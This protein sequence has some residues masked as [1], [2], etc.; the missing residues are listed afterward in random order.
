[1]GLV[2]H[3]CDRAE[4]IA[5]DIEHRSPSD[6]IGVVVHLFQFR[7]R[8]PIRL[9]HHRVPRF[10]AGLRVRMLLSELLESASLND[11]HG[12]QVL[13]MRTVSQVLLTLDP[14][15]VIYNVRTMEEM[16]AGS[17]AE[18]RF[19][20]ALLGI[21]AAIAL[22]LAMIGIYGVVSYLVSQRTHEIGIR[23]AL[24]AQRQ[25]IF[26]LVMIQG[27]RIGLVGIVLGL[28]ASFGLTRLLET[29]LFGVSAYDPVTFVGVAVVLLTVVLLACY[30]PA[31]RAMRVDP[32]V[33][34]RY[35]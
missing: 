27:G 6:Q 21:F 14:N 24:G 8:F 22:L 19:S 28:V 2:V 32:M 3:S 29:I 15:D 16:I 33:A 9:A 17:L 25:E 30:L 12:W 31:R 1:M 20:V 34:L 11:A 23:L 13:T 5:S 35:E 18:R 26:G 10:E 7:R 4:L